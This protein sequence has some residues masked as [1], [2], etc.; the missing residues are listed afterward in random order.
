[1]FFFLPWGHDQ[2]VYER[3]WATYALIAICCLIHVLGITTSQQAE[4]GVVAALTDFESVVALHPD[5]HISFA[6]N[7]LPARANAFIQPRVD[8]SRPARTP[9]DHALEASVLSLVESINQMPAF[10]YGW[11]SGAP[12]PMRLFTHM[13]LHADIFHLFGNMLLLWIAGGLLECFWRK[14]AFVALY[15]ASGLAGLFAQYVS[16]P[17]S[18]T[19]LIGAS[20]A[21]AGLL[22]AFVV[23]YPRVRIK[24]FWFY[25]FLLP[26]FGTWLAP[27]WF[28]LPLWVGVELL[29][30]FFNMG[31]EGGV[32]Y[33]AHVGGFAFGALA[34]LVAK[35]FH[36]VAEDAGYDRA[37]AP[38]VTPSAAPTPLRPTSIAPSSARASSKDLPLPL[39]LPM[40]SE[41]PRRVA[42]QAPR[43][44]ELS[45]LSEPTDDIIER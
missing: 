45:D 27:A 21:I 2:P 29:K 25:M 32:A 19:P 10:R 28:I 3:P 6:V 40:P 7:G 34:A 41:P 30:A 13:F 15:L 23:G 5:A 20:G 35:Q 31:E 8:E 4:L 16:S 42:R 38:P 11:R 18:L 12:T 22:G 44:L 39:P 17:Q 9:A 14:W 1:M 26:R 36:L 33:W 24:L 37:D 43:D